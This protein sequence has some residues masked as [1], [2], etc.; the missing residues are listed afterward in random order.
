MMEIIEDPDSSENCITLQ[1][2]IDFDEESKADVYLGAL[3]SVCSA[4]PIPL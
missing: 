1:E 3:R 2:F 4:T